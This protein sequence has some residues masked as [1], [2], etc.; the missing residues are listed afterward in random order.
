MVR[1]EPNLGFWNMHDLELMQY[2]NL[3]D[4]N[5]VKIY[6]G[7]IVKCIERDYEKGG[8]Y[9]DERVK[10]VVKFSSNWGVKIDVKF[11]S[12]QRILDNSPLLEN[13]NKFQV[14][15]NI[16]ENPELL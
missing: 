11:D 13:Y 3:K 5:G 1:L 14:I 7:D 10:G 16:Y 15:G 8:W 6:E 9:S 12:T 2:T 4:K